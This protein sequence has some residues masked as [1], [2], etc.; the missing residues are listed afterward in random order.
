MEEKPR[1]SAADAEGASPDESRGADGAAMTYTIEADAKRG[2]LLVTIRG[3]ATT[4]GFASL[5]RDLWAHPLWQQGMNL[6]LDH[7]PLDSTRLTSQAIRRISLTRPDPADPLPLRRIATVVETDLGF[8]LT[9]MW[10]FYSDRERNHEHRI[11]RSFEE[12]KRWL[13]EDP[14]A[15]A[16]E[17]K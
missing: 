17:R 6:L 9:R 7:R 13:E 5:S 11:F 4:D 10:D 15:G 14:P 12:A 2:F 8:G 1:H 3:R 16:T